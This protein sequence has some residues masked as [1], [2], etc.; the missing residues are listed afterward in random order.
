ML[1]YN[2]RKHRLNQLQFA[3][4]WKKINL[5]NMTVP[6]TETIEAFHFGIDLYDLNKFEGFYT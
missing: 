5:E 4:D 1:K 3:S 2:K 6:W